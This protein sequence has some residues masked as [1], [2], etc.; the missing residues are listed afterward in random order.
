MPIR[1]MTR[2]RKYV[3]QSIEIVFLLLPASPYFLYC[4]FDD[5]YKIPEPK[6]KLFG[7]VKSIVA[8]RSSIGVINGK[9]KESQLYLQ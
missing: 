8:H 7:K 4:R 6:E 9:S 5:K 1:K 3:F 2:I